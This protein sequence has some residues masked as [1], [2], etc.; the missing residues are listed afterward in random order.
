[1]PAGPGLPRAPPS[2]RPERPLGFRTGRGLGTLLLEVVKEALAGIAAED[3]LIAADLL[4]D[5]RLQADRAPL[6][7]AVHHP[8]Y[9]QPAARARDASELGDQ[10]GGDLSFDPAPAGLDLLPRR[11]HLLLLRGEKRLVR[12]NALHLLRQGC[13]FLP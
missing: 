4:D 13:F 9:R 3:P 8:G 12:L 10:I 6:T 2:M 11:L 5:P 1:M 7:Q